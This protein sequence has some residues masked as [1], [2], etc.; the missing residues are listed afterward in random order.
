MSK[1]P[2]KPTWALYS[3]VAPGELH[4]GVSVRPHNAQ[5]A[6]STW[7]EEGFFLA[8]AEFEGWRFGLL[9]ECLHAS[10]L[11][12]FVCSPSGV[13]ATIVSDPN[14]KGVEPLAIAAEPPRY[15]GCF[16]VQL[17]QPIDVLENVLS[18]FKS[19]LPLIQQKF[20]EAG[21][22]AQT[23]APNPSFQRTAFGSR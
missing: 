16:R 10:G 20:Q 3:P 12:A 19:A 18:G 15:A 11:M 14:A 7:H 9:Q 5:P 8:A 1:P 13:E 6:N 2:A 23:T 17:P 4:A 22:L 21:F